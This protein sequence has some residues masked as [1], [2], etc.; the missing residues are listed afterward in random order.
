MPIDITGTHNV[1]FDGVLLGI[2]RPVFQVHSEYVSVIRRSSNHYWTYDVENDSFVDVGASI[3]GLTQAFI[4]ATG[5]VD[6]KVGAFVDM[7]SLSKE[8]I[9]FKAEDIR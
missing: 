7:D 9:G 2:A 5:I 6:K 8:A 1:I 3:T 4:D